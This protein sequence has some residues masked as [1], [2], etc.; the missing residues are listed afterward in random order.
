FHFSMNDLMATEEQNVEDRLIYDRIFS[1]F[2]R[3]KVEISCAI[4]KTFP[5]L[6][7]L[8]DHEFITNKMFEDSQ[9]SCRNLVPVQRVVYNVLSELE[10]N[11]NLEVLKILFSD[12]HMKEYP[13]LIPIYKSFIN[14]LPD[15]S[16]LQES[17]EEGREEGPSSQLRLE[18]GWFR[19][20]ELKQSARL[21]TMDAGN[22]SALEKHSRKRRRRR[23]RP[24]INFTLSYRGRGKRYQVRVPRIPRDK[25]MN[26]QPPELPVTC[27][28][29]KGTLYKEKLEQGTSEKCI[30]SETGRWLTPRE[31]EIE[32]GRAPSKNWKLSIRCG[33]FTL[34][35]LIEYCHSIFL[36]FLQR[37]LKSHNDTLGDP[38]VKN[39]NI[40]GVCKRGGKLFC[41]DT[42]P[43]S[44]HEN[45]HIPLVEAERDPWSCIFCEIKVIQE[46]CPESQPCRRESEVLMMQMLPEVQLKCEFLLLKVYCD[47]KSL[48]FAS[49]PYYS[50]EGSQGPQ[51]PMWL[52]KVK[53]ML[54]E[55]M[56]PQ[57][58]EFVGDMRLIFQNHK[59]F[60]RENKF[61]K[62]GLQVENNFEKN[63]KNIFAIQETSK[64]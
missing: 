8:R 18:Q 48:F 15:K 13:D 6:E 59:A 29:I 58:K 51:R 36:S 38:Y 47:S 46:R 40:C 37:I 55:K 22:N 52:D 28:E 39:S 3:H 4:R 1:H 62:L 23:G 30:K 43:R 5:F 35:H 54:T 32:G 26:F 42:C 34:K 56:Y 64:N 20:P 50:R 10:K 11:F 25:N 31:F 63:F 19:T 21:D 17:D 61:I 27:G 16:Y 53:K 44:F 41:C 2:K 14:V 12:V 57:V 49:K 9:E 33:G 7:R 60:Y 45:C 24:R